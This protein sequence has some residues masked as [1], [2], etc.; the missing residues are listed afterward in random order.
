MKIEYKE[1]NDQDPGSIKRFRR[2]KE[3][4]RPGEIVPDSVRL[5]NYITCSSMSSEDFQSWCTD[6]TKECKE[7]KGC[8]AHTSFGKLK[9]M[10]LNLRLI[11]TQ[12][13]D[14][15]KDWGKDKKLHM[16][17]YG[18][19]NMAISH[20]EIW[21]EIELI[22]HLTK[23]FNDSR[24]KMNEF[25]S[26]ISNH[27]INSENLFNIKQGPFFTSH[28]GA[29]ASRLTN[30]YTYCSSEFE[31]IS[32]RAFSSEHIREILSIWEN[33][34][35]SQINITE[36]ADNILNYIKACISPE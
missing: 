3:Y 14:I 32:I 30:E 36:A 33:D 31:K 13:K 25:K 11:L 6:L 18:Y 17:N 10:S 24:V 19:L 35:S 4:I 29:T 7:I 5:S 21:R 22:K 12:S 2:I 20:P 28:K 16:G 9:I 1:N 23:S 26:T 27:Y 8:D 15:T 34:P